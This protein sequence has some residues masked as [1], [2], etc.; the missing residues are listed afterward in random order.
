M[1]AETYWISKTVVIDLALTDLAGAPITN[2]TVAA[3]ITQ[4]DGTTVPASVALAGSVYRA[5]F[6]P[7]AA[8]TYAYRLVATGTADSAEEGT[9]E[10]RASPATAAAPTL[11]PATGIG[12][13]RLL[14][15]DRDLDNLLFTDADITALLALED[16]VAKRAAAAGLESIAANEALVGKVIK[17]QDLSTDG[18]R[19]AEAL[20][21]RAAE[22]R[23]QADEDDPDTGGGFDYVEFIDPFHRSAGELA[24]QEL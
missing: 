5:T 4:P 14:I 8:G 23:R 21:K 22:L 24:E 2:A 1:S 13:V 16:A 9:F 20:M 10:V 3:T 19:T 6:D 15:P 18:A 12:L 17:S 7:P 11:D